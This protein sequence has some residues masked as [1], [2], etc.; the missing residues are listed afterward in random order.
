M[1]QHAHQDQSTG[2]QAHQDGFPPE[3]AHQAQSVGDIL[4][5]DGRERRRIDARTRAFSA[6]ADL[7]AQAEMEAFGYVSPGLGEED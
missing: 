6:E 7:I 4:Y 1:R 3:H 5:A 2:E